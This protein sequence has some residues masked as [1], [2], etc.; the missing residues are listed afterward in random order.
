MPL[1]GEGG[2]AELFFGAAIARAGSKMEKRNAIAGN[3]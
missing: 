2:A 1:D 3:L